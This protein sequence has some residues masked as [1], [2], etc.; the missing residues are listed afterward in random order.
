MEKHYNQHAYSLPDIN[1]GS[2]VAIQNPIT[3]RWDIY[4]VVTEIGPYSC[5][6][7]KT[8]SGHVLVRNRHF[9]RRCVPISPHEYSGEPPSSP[10]S[11]AFHSISHSAQTSHRGDLIQ[12][13]CVQAQQGRGRCGK[14]THCTLNLSFFLAQNSSCECLALC[15]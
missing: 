4:G 2:N 1:I 6:H 3:K 10:P 7:I 11:S 14:L 15:G 12:V 13:A 8:A 9:L 5:Y